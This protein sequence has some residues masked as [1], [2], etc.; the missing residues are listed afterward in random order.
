M[1]ENFQGDSWGLIPPLRMPS[2]LPHDLCHR[3]S[4]L[5]ALC[6]IFGCLYSLCWLPKC[7]SLSLAESAL[8]IGL[9]SVYLDFIAF[10]LVSLTR[11]SKKSKTVSFL[12]SPVSDLDLTS[13]TGSR[14]CKW[15]P[16]VQEFVHCWW[17]CKL[18]Q[19]LWKTVWS[20]L[21]ETKNRVAMWSSSTTP[22]HISVENSNLKKF[23]H[24]NV[25][26]S[27]IYN[28]QDMEANEMSINTWMDKDAI[29][30]HNGIL[31]SHKKNEILDG[32]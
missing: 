28:S 12:S 6:L 9:C 8:K 22:G 10:W 7:S 2:L 13:C 31:I 17:E 15:E 16:T 24:S 30:M 23:M 5:P 32:K 18:M 1:L 19:P 21:K 14:E 26:S 3:R 4:S 11:K 29:Y 27:T 25:H 20:A